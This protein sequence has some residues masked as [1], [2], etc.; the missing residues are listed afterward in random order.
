[1]DEE[2]EDDENVLTLLIRVLKKLEQRTGGMFAKPPTQRQPRL[3]PYMTEFLRCTE[4]GNSLLARCSGC[5]ELSAGF[6]S[7][8]I[9]I[10]SPGE[11]E[12]FCRECIPECI[13]DGEHWLPAP[14]FSRERLVAFVRGAGGPNFR[15]QCRA[16]HDPVTLLNFHAAHN[17][18]GSRGGSR[19][20][21][22]LR[23]ACS[24][25]NSSTGNKTFDVY[26]RELQPFLPPLLPLEKAEE[27][28][29]RLFGE[30]VRD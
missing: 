17:I 11:T 22:N 21:S 3:K 13:E 4:D 9:R 26:A 1:M 20:A 23:T 6:V 8:A 5:A 27:I 7:A 2:A 28:T 12:I 25:C 29:A 10:V 19:R 15:S 24:T 14:S 30:R 16:C 18:A